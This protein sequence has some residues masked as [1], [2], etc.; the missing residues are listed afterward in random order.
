MCC[1]PEPGT[2]KKPSIWLDLLF[3]GR[4]V[5]LSEGQL[6][7]TQNLPV[8]KII[9]RLRAQSLLVSCLI[10]LNLECPNH[11]KTRP[12]WYYAR[13]NQLVKYP[14]RKE[15]GN[16]HSAQLCNP[17]SSFLTVGTAYMV[18]WR[19]WEPLWIQS[20]MGHAQW[21]ACEITGHFSANSIWPVTSER[22]R[23]CGMG[24]RRQQRGFMGTGINN[25]YFKEWLEFWHMDMEQ[26]VILWRSNC[27]LWSSYMDICW[28]HVRNPES[29]GPLQACIIRIYSSVRSL[30]NSFA[31]QSLR[32]PLLD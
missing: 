25:L 19:N 12:C 28:K 16:R 15:M 7:L 30:D 22:S 3:S 10:R 26:R 20:S 1:T 5:S 8:I 23:F 4:D 11:L 18:Q 17:I 24:V 9:Q 32:S 21:R 29:W 14:S 2:A 6:Q 13:L 31:C 27:G